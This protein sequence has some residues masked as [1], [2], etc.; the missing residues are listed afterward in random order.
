M[1]LNQ[2]PHR[3]KYLLD[4]ETAG[5]SHCPFRDS[6]T[7]LHASH[8]PSKKDR[9]QAYKHFAAAHAGAYEKCRHFRR[10]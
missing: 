4:R 8:H 7:S 9:L 3:R 1:Q 6:R 5:L 2:T 10:G